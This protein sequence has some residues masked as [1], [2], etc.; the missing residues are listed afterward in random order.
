MSKK[1]K[2]KIQNRA[3]LTESEVDLLSKQIRY[4][5]E[6]IDRYIKVIDLLVNKEKCPKDASTLTRLRHRLQ[7]AMDESDTFRKVLWRHKK[8]SH[9]DDGIAA[10]SFL[11]SQIKSRRQALMVQSAMK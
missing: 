2:T 4:N 3:L 8:S 5:S 7:I 6:W 9:S 10:M 1:L 11:I